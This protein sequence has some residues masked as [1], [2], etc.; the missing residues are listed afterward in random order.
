LASYCQDT[1]PFR[2]ATLT[3]GNRIT[4]LSGILIGIFTNS[5]K[6]KTRQWSHEYLQEY[7]IVSAQK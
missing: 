1:F 2:V 7:L 3:K 4:G 5:I 6:I